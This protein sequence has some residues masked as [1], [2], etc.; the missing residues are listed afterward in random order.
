[1]EILARAALVVHVVFGTAGLLAFWFPVLTRKGARLHKLSGRVFLWSA[2]TMLAAA[3][4]VLLVRF[5][6]LFQAGRYPS[7]SPHR[8]ALLFLL[9]QIVIMVWVTVRHGVLV[10]RY[11]HAPGE[12]DTGANKLLAGIVILASTLLVGYA[13]V[14]TPFNMMVLIS[15]GA[16]GVFTG[17]DI[18][19]YIRGSKAGPQAWKV[20][21]LGAMLGAG[22]AYHTAFAVFG[23]GRVVDLSLQGGFM[24]VPW[25]LPT[26]I[27]IPAI[28]LWSRHYRIN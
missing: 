24:L 7:E 14:Y 12:L 23:M 21:H 28:L 6:L 8:F 3:S 13:L 18:L 26:L 2:H 11:K 22:I 27:G 19:R 17:I 10:L 15:L 1:M 25:L 9:A 4:V 20:E 16:V 5:T